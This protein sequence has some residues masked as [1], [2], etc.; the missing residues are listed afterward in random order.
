[1]DVRKGLED[2]ENVSGL[3]S[4]VHYYFI[5]VGTANTMIA[6]ATRPRY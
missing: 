2:D 1:V 4:E 3:H 5:A 6:F